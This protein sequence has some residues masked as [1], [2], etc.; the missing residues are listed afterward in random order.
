MIAT[1][2]RTQE[3]DRGRRAVALTVAFG[4][5]GC[6]LTVVAATQVAERDTARAE[7]RA[8]DTATQ[9]ATTLELDLERE[10]DMVVNGRA[11]VRQNPDLTTSEMTEWAR[12]IEMSRRFPEQYGVAIIRV[13]TREQLPAY[14]AA[15]MR[16]PS[17][18]LTDGQFIP[19]PPGDRDFYCFPTA[20]TGAAD[21]LPAGLDFCATSSAPILAARDSGRGSY[22]PV[23]ANGFT[24]LGIQEPV[25]RDG[26]RLTTVAER[27][28]AFIGW[29][30]FALNPEVL[31]RRAV[32]G[33]GDVAVRIHY[34]RY[35]SDVSFRTGTIDRGAERVAID[36]E[37]GWTIE[38]FAAHVPSGLLASGG[39]RALFVAGSAFTLLVAVLLLVLATGR[40]RAE[41]L[42]RLKT[43]ELRYQALHDSLTGLANRA[44]LSDRIEHLLAR[45]RRTGTSSSVLFLDLDGFKGVNDTLGHD[46]GD[47]LLKAVAGRLT[48]AVRE[49]DTIGRLGGDEFVIVIDGA[50]LDAAPHLVAERVVS[51]LRQPFE[52]EGV[53]RPLALSASVGVAVTDDGSASDLLRDADTAMYL[54]KSAGKDGY[55]VFEPA[56][57]VAQREELNLDLDLRSALSAGQFRLVYQ[58]IYNLDDLSLLSVEALL[59][60]EHPTRGTI[61]P[62]VFIP[63]LER[64]GAIVDVGR[65]VL[66]QACRQMAAWRD[67]GTDLSVSVN[68]SARQLDSDAVIDDVAFALSV[69]GL[70]PERLVIEITESAL[71][72]DI[73]QSAARVRALK[74]LG[75]HVAIDDFG[76]GYSSLAYL[77]QLPVDSLKIDRSFVSAMDPSP[78][79]QAIVRTI[80]QLG[81][82]L[83]LKTLA[84]GVETTS[85]VDQLRGERVDEAQGFLL[86]RP[87]DPETFEAT[88]LMKESQR[89]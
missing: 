29:F 54:S 27:R 72:R 51:V 86:A 74:G 70:E 42:V 30:G 50:S 7:D 83:G 73:E 38:T 26:T 32:V 57:E 17:G 10:S 78:E 18:P 28:A 48:S 21:P 46:V 76:T 16:N 69:S 4:L 47:Q 44:L 1:M 65:W 20:S 3:R 25:Y 43:E 66:Q 13:V 87:L 64:S 14:A 60:W 75:V 2:T 53:D 39:S 81:R 61:A 55:V 79:S 59:R 9:I 22:E 82:E 6:G 62:V 35:G 23:T 33:H 58:P 67:L 71:M 40:S 19:L 34:Q 80:V 52:L 68:V 24:F 63:L 8:R 89:R 45:N 88:I 49:A 12:D 11:L 41:R 85:Q 77:Q 15:A 36:L 31:L 37:N 84:E 5:L 56:M